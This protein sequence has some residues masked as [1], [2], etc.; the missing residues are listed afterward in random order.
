[1][2]GRQSKKQ[3]AIVFVLFIALLWIPLVNAQTPQFELD[4]QTLTAE[5]VEWYKE[6]GSLALG[7]L[8][9]YGNFSLSLTNDTFVDRVVF[10]IESSTWNDSSDPFSWE[11]STLDFSIGEYT[12]IV[13]AYSS[14]DVTDSKE[15]TYYFEHEDRHLE[16]IVPDVPIWVWLVVGVVFVLVLGFVVCSKR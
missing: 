4:L 1:M 8:H 7:P 15:V 12:I 13:T 3:Y 5:S 2:N 11:F 6:P 9:I 16:S 14:E 10:Q